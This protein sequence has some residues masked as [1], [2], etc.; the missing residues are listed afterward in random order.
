MK[1]RFSRFNIRD[2][3]EFKKGQLIPAE[4]EEEEE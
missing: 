2:K 3:F 1:L 4:R